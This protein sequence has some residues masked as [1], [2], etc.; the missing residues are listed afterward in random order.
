[1]PANV[2]LKRFDLDY[3]GLVSPNS[4]SCSTFNQS[5]NTCT[6]Y[7]PSASSISEPASSPYALAVGAADVSGNNACGSD[8]S[9][10]G[11]FPLENY[12]AQ[13]PTIDSRVKP[14]IAAFD[15][16]T[17]SI[18]SPFCGTS[19]S[20]PHVA[21]A[22]ALVAQTHP[23]YTAD[24][25]Q[26]FLTQHA[27]GGA[28]FTPPS[29]ALGAGVLALGPAPT[30]SLTVTLDCTS[31]FKIATAMNSLTVHVVAT[32][33]GFSPNQQYQLSLMPPQQGTLTLN[34]TADAN[35]T[36]SINQSA[37]EVTNL[38]IAVGNAV[39]WRVLT[40][41]Q[42]TLL[43]SGATT[44]SNPCGSLAGRRGPVT[45]DYD[46]S[47]DGY[48]DL[49]A[50]DL[51]GRLLYY[52]NNSSTNAGHLPFTTPVV[53]GSGWYGPQSNISL[54]TAGDV[55][56]DGY[57]DLVA[58]TTSGALLLYTNNRTSNAGHPPYGTG[59]VIGSGWKSFN[60]VVL[61]DVS[62]D[63]YADI[64]ATRVSDGSLWYYPNNILSNPGHMPFN[65]GIEIASGV[66][67]AAGLGAGDVNGDGY[68][69]LVTSSL[70]VIQ[71]NLVPAG[72]SN[73]FSSS[74]LA[75]SSPSDQ[76]PTAGFAV[77]DY[78][79]T[80]SDGVMAAS[81]SGSG[82]LIYIKSPLTGLPAAAQVIGSGWQTIA[83]IIP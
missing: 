79:H 34:V 31:R 36:L 43:L 41:G 10:T 55:N 57:T 26:S 1:V 14:D 17:G 50:I 61:G 76:S 33:T 42:S 16:T 67:Y 40:A 52:P 66:Q 83:R 4:L 53:I 44:V 47:G 9:G 56:G 29:E 49:L 3:E 12:S 24:Q 20:A 74:I 18:G 8:M 7:T 6:A 11:T 75:I 65:T 64:I 46:V 38:P 69:D 58:T 27:N 60:N 21:G 51:A 82:Q 19:A 59:Q 68:A 77:G 71:P 54:V 39:A 13:G 5:T 28:P 35:G 37:T 32:L 72:N 30:G 62:G 23:T 48:A 22:A 15:G 70:G 81:P 78:E 2:P 45:H 63:G 80:G 25:L 73:F